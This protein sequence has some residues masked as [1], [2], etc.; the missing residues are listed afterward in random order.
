M[1]TKYRA[2]ILLEP[3]QHKTLQEIAEREGRSL[4]DVAREVI[5]KGLDAREHEMEA[6]WQKRAAALQRLDQIREAIQEQQGIYEGDLLGE[7]RS[8]REQQLNDAL[9]WKSGA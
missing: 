1:S 3:E 4:S 6:I 9:G 2:Q 7:V 8:E 5:Q